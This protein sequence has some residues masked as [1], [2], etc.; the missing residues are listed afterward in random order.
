MAY[1]ILCM[2]VGVASFN[3]LGSLTM[4]V[5][6]KTRDIGILRTMG[7]TREMIL[8][9]FMHQG[10]LVGILGSLFGVL[11]GVLVVYLQKEFHLVPL[12]PSVYIIP[13]IPV[14]LNVIDLVLISLT[15]I[16]LCSV[17]AYYPARRAANLILVEAIRWE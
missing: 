10:L 1:I 4:S 8:K 12:D 2:I 13:A 16:G 15:G 3:L 11:L 7:A 17:A 9:I 14:E 6:D 5:I